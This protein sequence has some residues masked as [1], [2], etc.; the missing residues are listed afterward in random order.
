MSV[1][2]KG[3]TSGALGEIGLPVGVNGT[4]K[5]LLIQP[6]PIAYGGLGHYRLSVR[7][8]LVN[9]QAANSRLFELRNTG[10]NKIILTRLLIRWIQT[11]AHT[12][13]I[14]DSIDAYKLTTFTAVDTTNTVTPTASQKRSTMGAA[15]GNVAIRH[16]TVAGAAAG[17]TGGTLTKDGNAFSI[18]PKWLLLAVP[19]AAESVPMTYDLVDDVNG[20]HP[21][22]Y[23]QNEGFELENRV[24]L[25]AAAGSDVV[26]DCSYVEVA[27]Y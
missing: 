9:A 24:L 23:A 25:G 27:D 13:A 10:T 16:V 11:A 7:F 6:R 19:T 5:S 14:L 26:V 17:M 20:T 21:F 2:L 3:G 12:V 18:I 15:P 22:V 8:A 1:I 4:E